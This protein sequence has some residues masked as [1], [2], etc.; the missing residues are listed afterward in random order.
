MF[1]IVEVMENAVQ[2]ILG[3][4]KELIEAEHELSKIHEER[5]DEIIGWDD[6]YIQIEDD[7]YGNIITY[8]IIEI[9]C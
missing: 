1:V 7:T 5:K 9:Q 4:Y 2:R 8:Q 6:D 3:T